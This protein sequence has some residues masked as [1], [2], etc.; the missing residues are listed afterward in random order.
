MLVAALWQWA[1]FACGLHSP[2]LQCGQTMFA[3]AALF[4]VSP[5]LQ[6]RLV[7]AAPDARALLLAANFVAV[8][9]GQAAGAGLGGLALG[10]AGLT[11]AAAVGVLA[12]VA[13][14]IA[15]ARRA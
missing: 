4:S 11:G 15:A 2:L 5:V 14:L 6:A 7:A 9:L 3:S 12:A 1:L 8:S 13:M 10:A